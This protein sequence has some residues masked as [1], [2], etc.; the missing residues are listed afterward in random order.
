MTSSHSGKLLKYALSLHQ[1]GELAKAA[2]IY[3][4]IRAVQP[5]N[6]DALHLGGLAALQQGDAAAAAALLEQAC[7]LNPHSAL[8]RLRLGIALDLL[9]RFPESE[10]SL[11]AALA[12]DPKAREAW[13]HLGGSLR[14][15]GRLPEAEAAFAQALVLKEDYA[16]AHERLGALLVDLRG[17]AA[18]EPHFRRAAELQPRGATAWSNL[19]VCLLYLG[20][21]GDAL[22]AFARALAIDPRL[23]H[24]YAGK[25]LTL[26]RCYQLSGAVQSYERALAGNPRNHQARSARLV[27]LQYLGDRSRELIFEEHRLAGAAIAGPPRREFSRSLEPQRRLRIGFLSPD[28]HRH[29]V[30][31]F[32]EPLLAHLDRSQFEVYL[33]H[34]NSTVDAASERLHRLVPNW[35]VVAGL[36]DDVL[37]GI[38]RG[39]AL[40]IL[41]DLAGHTGMNRLPLFA[42]RLAP[43]QATYLGYPDTTGLPAMDYRLVDEIT[44]PPGEAEAFCSEKLLRFAPTAWC[45]APPAEAPAP[46]PPPSL[47]GREV[48]FGCF[49]NFAKVTDHALLAW[50]RLL[51]TVPSSRLLFK[52]YGLTVPALQSAAGRRLAA[53]GI[54]AERVEFMERTRTVEE[55]LALYGRIDVALDTFPYHGTT[56]TCESLWMG[57]P[58]ISLVGDRHAS[59]VGASLLQAVG[60]SEW[61]ARDWHDYV[62]KAAACAGDQAGRTGLRL[63]LREQMRASALLGH[64]AQAGRFGAALREIWRQHCSSQPQTGARKVA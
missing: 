1:S 54:A 47:R 34:D 50:S 63:G 19:G 15:Q 38:L 4:R 23:D 24:A 20:R 2:A 49:N 57:V 32:I 43:L 25:G 48:T 27:A 30:A 13:F 11:R 28:L 64:A 26:E 39:D 51:Q 3:G 9:R 8:A 36:D 56:T 55:H 60:H 42:R 18:A 5:R 12:I 31:Y 41:F 14:K 59:R 61:L 45:Y 17:H 7:P 16:E 33:Y 37:E 62:M 44:D 29:S 40:D 6:F 21:L 58:V 22:G 46:V 35:R 53:A 52:G 10:T